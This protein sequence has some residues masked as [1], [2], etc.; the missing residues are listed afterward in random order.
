M[1]RT[2]RS[3]VKWGRDCGATHHQPHRR[4]VLIKEDNDVY[5]VG[6]D[7]SPLLWAPLENQ[8][9]NSNM[10]LPVRQAE[11]S[12]HEEHPESVQRKNTKSFIRVVQDH[13][14][15]GWPGKDCYSLDRKFWFTCCIH[16]PLH[17]QISIYV[18]RYRILLMEENAN[19][20]KNVKDI[21]DRSLLKK[22]NNFGKMELW[23]CLKNCRR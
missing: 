20:L 11:G 8:M 15:L 7:G 22:I 4:P 12:T 19:S 13:M 3:N 6:L 9:I 23:C 10:L 17:L 2:L 14:F 16:Q 18:D 21:W 1:E 5:T